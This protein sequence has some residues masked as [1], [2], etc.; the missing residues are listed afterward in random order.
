MNI[1]IAQHLTF[2]SSKSLNFDYINL[3]QAK[4]SDVILFDGYIRKD[5]SKS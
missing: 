5:E 3:F 2:A 1:L 4:K